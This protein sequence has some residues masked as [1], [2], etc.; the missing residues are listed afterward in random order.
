MLDNA[1]EKQKSGI[2]VLVG[3]VNEDTSDENGFEVDEFTIGGL[4]I[5]YG[6]RIVKF[7]GKDIYNTTI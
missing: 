1:L 2:D 3:H 6:K 7:N 5:I 4:C